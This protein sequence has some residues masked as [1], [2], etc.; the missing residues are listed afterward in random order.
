MAGL[1]LI[2]A[3]WLV[4]AFVSSVEREKTIEGMVKQSDGMVRLFEEYTVEIVERLDRT[5]LLLRKSYEDDPGHFDLRSW[6]ARTELVGDETHQIALIGANGYRVTSTTD[7]QGPPTYVGDREYF[8][9]QLD[10]ASDKLFISEPVVGRVTGKVSLQFSRRV[11]APGGG[12][13]GVILIS[14]NPNFI[15]RFYRAVD[16]GEKGSIVLRNLDGVIIAAQGLSTGAGRQT[17]QHPFL[18]ALARSR[19][20]SYWGGGAIDGHNRLV[21]YR[22]SDKFPLIFAL[23]L[24]ESDGLGAYWKHRTTY[25]AVA[26]VLSCIVLIAMAFTI[27]HQAKLDESQ[28]RLRLLNEESSEQNVRFDAALANMSSGISMFDADGELVVWNDRYVEIYGMA[29]ELIRLGVSIYTIIEHRKAAGNLD[30]DVDTYIGNFQQQLSDNGR[31][32][33]SSR[34]R[35]GRVVSVVSTAI[36]NGGW[37]GI[38]EDITE[39]IDHE[40]S[41]Y[42][43]ATELALVNMRFDAALSNMTQGVC[44]F[45]AHKNLVIVNR[46]FRE[47]YGF[48]E[49]QVVPGTPLSEMLQHHARQGMTSDLT[50][51]EHLQR[52]PTEADQYFV[53]VA[54]RVISIKRTPTADGGWVATHED[55][56]AQ[57]RAQQ[58]IAEKA[59]ELGH[60]NMQFDAALSNM[61]QGISMYDSGKRLVVWNHRYAELYRLPQGFL[62][63]GIHVDEVMTEI[64]ARNVLKQAATIEDIVADRARHF[65][66]DFNTSR[67]DEFADGR[68]V[69]IS[70]QAMKEGGWVSTHE[71][72]TERRRAEA[73][74]AHLARH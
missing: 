26:A 4:A 39:R 34:L 46:R 63:A 17:K 22:T 36:G 50:I 25:F 9:T 7:Y 48:L 40:T 5:L 47:M 35:D 43:Q 19:S 69:L 12:F 27:R 55:V 10:Q 74:I 32:I 29:P 65:S 31:S 3:C 14:I 24:A 30:L 8:R 18:E 21:T 66:T 61:S 23:G 67:I 2:A 71:D 1:I 58:L 42:H 64:F 41:I 51:E 54:G 15:G 60:I 44:L 16:L 70:R 38:H 49:E 53:T 56:T 72:I 28:G 20:G 33:S 37:V 62:K 45:D 68:V 73:E 11:R 6:S 52:I 57:E 13:G 59:A